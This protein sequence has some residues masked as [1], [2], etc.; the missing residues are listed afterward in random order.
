MKNEIYVIATLIPIIW[1][2]IFWGFVT[3]TLLIAWVVMM[4]IA[5]VAKLFMMYEKQAT[6]SKTATIP[7][8]N[9]KK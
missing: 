5:I 2:L 6:D 8:H 3:H 4:G 1:G 7:I 9:H